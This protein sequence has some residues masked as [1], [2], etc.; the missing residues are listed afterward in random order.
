MHGTSSVA[1][2]Q[3]SYLAFFGF[4]TTPISRGFVVAVSND[5]VPLK[6]VGSPGVGWHVQRCPQVRGLAAAPGA[7]PPSRCVVAGAVT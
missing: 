5:A 4:V 3:P 7:W 2:E 1:R 6:P